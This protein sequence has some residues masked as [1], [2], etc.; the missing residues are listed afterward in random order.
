MTV[1]ITEYDTDDDTQV[2]DVFAVLSA[3]AV[4]DQPDVPWRSREQYVREVRQRSESVHAHRLLAWIDG[5]IAGVGGMHLPMRDNLH[6]ADVMI[7]VWP[8]MR[9]RGA[10]RALCEAL[11]TIARERGRRVLLSA[12]Q[13]A[14]P[15]GVARPGD[16]AAF[17]AA[18]GAE[19][20]LRSVH[21][22][23]VL[24][25]ADLTARP[26]ATG[27][28]AI[29]WTGAV[30][31]ELID[32]VAE[33]ASL[34]VLDKPTGDLDVEPPTPDPAV[35]RENE[36]AEAATGHRAYGVAARHDASGVLA[37]YTRLMVPPD[38]TVAH[39][40]G[41]FVRR[42]FRGHRLGF[43]V[44]IENLIRVRQTEPDVRYI[45]TQ[46]ANDNAY[47]V[48]INDTLGFRPYYADVTWQL[49]L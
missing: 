24:A 47:M 8:D 36:R 10:G 13:S 9:R 49:T 46:N 16:G 11:A 33:L 30:P 34:V 35:Y 12:T 40:L 17:A 7:K 42:E 3:V 1:T 4:H 2:T 14:V 28:S 39:Q 29:A 31:D 48:A 45:Y 41:T 23:L 5:E 20:G 22:R 19:E 15:G 43:L 6:L 38:R 26:D 44:K 25:N 37:G 32:G 27:F 21:L 18:V